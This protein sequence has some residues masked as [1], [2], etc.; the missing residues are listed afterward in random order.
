MIRY[1]DTS[2]NLLYTL[3]IDATST[4]NGGQA[5]TSTDADGKIISIPAHEGAQNNNSLINALRNINASTWD[6]YIV[7]LTD[8]GGSASSH[9][10]LYFKHCY[11]NR[12]KHYQIAWDNGVGFFDYYTFE[13]K[14]EHSD[15][16]EKKYY[17]TNVG[18]WEA[19]TFKETPYEHGTIPHQVRRE[20]RYK[21]S[22]GKIGEATA[23]YLR[24]L[25]YSR[26]IDLIDDEGNVCPVILEDQ[27]L[28]YNVDK[29]TSMREYTF[30]FKLA[31]EIEA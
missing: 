22:T 30:T 31:N 10:M 9:Q 18:S 4:G 3:T 5:L 14:S 27:N 26:R 7:D 24:S 1:Y 6:Y 2:D 23:E 15:K 11:D 19:S 8:S 17:S 16:V 29:S 13:L 12:F 28:T 20:K 25:V 21:L